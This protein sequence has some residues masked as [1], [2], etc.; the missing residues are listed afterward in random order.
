MSLLKLGQTWECA[1]EIGTSIPE[2]SVLLVVELDQ[3]ADGQPRAH[4]MEEKSKR[5][6]FIREEWI[7]KGYFMLREEK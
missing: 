6:Y 5:I 7:A 2:G 4:V 3:S 1:Q